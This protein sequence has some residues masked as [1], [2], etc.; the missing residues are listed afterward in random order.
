MTEPI[1]RAAE[2][3]EPWISG[4]QYSDFRPNEWRESRL[5]AARAVFASI[6]REG[7]ARVVARFMDPSEGEVLESDYI[8]TDNILKH[9]TGAQS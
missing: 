8:L 6:D 1:E 2:A 5:E 7:L 4:D 9:L 3:L